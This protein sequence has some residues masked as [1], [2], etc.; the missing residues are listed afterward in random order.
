MKKFSAFALLSVLALG[1]A[2]EAPKGGSTPPVGTPGTPHAAHMDQ[3][4]NHGAH[5][6][7]ADAKP[8]EGGEAA[9]PA[10][11]AEAAKPAEGAE[12][13]KPAEGEAAAPAEKKE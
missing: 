13:A 12:A 7:P 6:A 10:E 3:M 5:A 8:A 11:G 2:A 9:K 1:C 4:L